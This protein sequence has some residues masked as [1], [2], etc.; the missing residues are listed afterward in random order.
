MAITA[1]RTVIRLLLDA[2]SWPPA[3]WEVL[4]PALVAFVQAA[5]TASILP[6]RACDP[7]HP[8]T[9]SMPLALASYPFPRQRIESRVLY[10]RRCSRRW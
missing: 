8:A 2:S 6:G 10:V 5:L 3:R 1:C 4:G 9:S 7:S